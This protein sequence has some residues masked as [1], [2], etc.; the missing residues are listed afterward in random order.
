MSKKPIIIAV[1]GPAG[2]G[3]SSICSQ[4]ASKLGFEYINTG[5][6]YR[7][8]GLLAQRREVDFSDESSMNRLIEDLLLE[9]RFEGGDLFIGEEN[10]S[11]SLLDEKVG[12]LASAVAVQPFVRKLLKPVQRRLALLSKK[13]AILDGRDIGTVIF[14]D[15]DRKVFMT[16]SAEVRAKRRLAQLQSSAKKKPV[17]SL[18]YL[19]ED[20]KKRDKQDQNRGVA[21]LKQADNADLLDTSELTFDQSVETLVEMIQSRES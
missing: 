6:L 16:A 18:H 15:A 3:K 14:P 4:A 8:V 17:P 19:L 1:D 20:M 11:P 10:L 5:A 21:P 12:A 13:G 9:I 7:A 2:S